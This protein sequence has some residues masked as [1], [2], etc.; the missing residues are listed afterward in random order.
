MNKIRIYFSKKLKEEKA[1][2]YSYLD[3]VQHSYKHVLIIES[4]ENI[5]VI[6]QEMWTF[7]Q[8]IFLPHM[9]LSEVESDFELTNTKFILAETTSNAELAFVNLTVYIL[10]SL[11]TIKN[12]NLLKDKDLSIFLSEYEDYEKIISCVKSKAEEK[13]EW[14]FDL[15]MYQEINS[16]WQEMKDGNLFS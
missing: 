15:K 12:I 8:K 11:Y 9:L 1:T 10:P 14:S 16:K 13:L 3:K 4:P 7:S 5:N 6:N 2:I